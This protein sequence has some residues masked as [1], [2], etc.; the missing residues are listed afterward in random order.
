LGKRPERAA[1]FTLLTC[2]TACIGAT[3]YL[4]VSPNVGERFTEFYILGP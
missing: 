3:I 4:A 1:T 2:L